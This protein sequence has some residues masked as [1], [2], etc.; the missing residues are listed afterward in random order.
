MHF[1]PL[2][3]LSLVLSLGGTTTAAP[4]TTASSEPGAMETA[5]DPSGMS[6]ASPLFKRDLAGWITYY[7]AGLGAC[8][9]R[10]T[11]TERVV[12]MS[13]LFFNKYNVDANPNNNLLCGHW[14]SVTY[15]GKTVEARI[16]DMCGRCAHNDIDLS[17]AAFKALAPLS[18][19]MMQGSWKMIP[20]PS[21]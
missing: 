4:V 18:V 21:A 20:R 12:A 17:Q 8:G 11:G 6:P 5:Q 15:Q 9:W 10:N 3:L 1:Q 16:V 13:R 2:A 7:H 19:G 14:I